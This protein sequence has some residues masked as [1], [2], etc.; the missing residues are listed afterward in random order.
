MSKP[1]AVVE[2]RPRRRKLKAARYTKLPKI[3]GEKGTDMK[4]RK[5]TK[6]KA[7]TENEVNG[8]EISLLSSDNNEALREQ[9]IK[10]AV[11]LSYLRGKVD[12][13]SE[14][15]YLRG[16]LDAYESMMVNVKQHAVTAFNLSDQA[17]PEAP[18]P[19]HWCW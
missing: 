11:D 16:K 6:R 18:A 17:A 19:A 2:G 4:P 5:T 15:S 12:S 13:V 8:V 10:L 9:D 3:A 14:S 1:L 7:I